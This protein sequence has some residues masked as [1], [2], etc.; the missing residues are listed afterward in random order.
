MKKLYLFVLDFSTSRAHR[1]R[2]DDLEFTGFNDEPMLNFMIEKGHSPSN[3]E[4][5]TTDNPELEY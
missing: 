2:V 5:M 4:W 3:C 1:Y